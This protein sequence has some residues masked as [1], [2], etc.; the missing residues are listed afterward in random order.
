[1][2]LA[3]AVAAIKGSRN[4]TPHG[5]ARKV[6]SSRGPAAEPTKA[7][8][9]RVAKNS[10]F[11]FVKPHANTEATRALVSAGLTAAGLTILHEGSLGAELIDSKR[12]I[13]QHYYAIASKA[14]IL[15]PAQLNV[16]AALFEKTFGVPWADALQSGNVLNAMD[17]CARLGID[18]A[19]MEA[20]WRAAEAAKKLVKFGG[21]FY[22][23]LV[24]VDGHAPVYVFNGFFMAMRNKFTAPGVSIHYY[25]VEWDASQTS[26]KSFRGQLLGPTDPAAAPA[27]SLRGRINAQWQALGLHAAPNVGDN[28][29][30]ASASPFEALAER[31][32]WV[33]AALETDAFGASLLAAGIPAATI[34]EWTLDPQV[35]VGDGS[36]N[37]S[38]FDALEDTNAAE[39]L[40]ECKRLWLLNA[41]VPA[42]ASAP[43]AAVAA[44]TKSVAISLP[45][46][47]PVSAVEGLGDDIPLAEPI[48]ETKRLVHRGRVLQRSNPVAAF[49]AFQR[50]AALL[51]QGGSADP[52]GEL[53][54]C[55]QFSQGTVK[56]PA[57]AFELATRGHA[58]GSV[59]ATSSLA[60][61][62]RTGTGCERDPAKAFA[63]FSLAA[64]GQEP[65]GLCGLGVCYDDGIG[66]DKDATKAAACYEKAA[67][68]GHAQSISIIGL[69]YA[70]GSG[71]A[72]DASR[73]VEFYQRGA[74]LGHANSICNLGVCF[75]NG[76]GVDK[77]VV[78]A[79]ACYQRGAELGHAHSMYYLGLCYEFGKGA[80]DKSKDAAKAW[81]KKAAELG[82]LDAKKRLK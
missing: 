35:K 32:N 16:P 18:S 36:K 76:T 50:A 64:E 25:V 67:E 40:A 6:A 45:P 82:D 44:P 4:S 47:P 7:A 63:L 1:M 59:L 15:K 80:L 71:V 72:K 51:E 62:Y 9:A 54:H 23:G 22:C 55:Y 61:C 68:L 33:G 38:L 5:T 43:V 2:Q 70:N 79:V 48:A 73:A 24:Q 29:V 57:L 49:D 10:A 20:A 81:F 11:V 19:Q 37:G 42:P 75:E 41:P 58:A 69:C 74:V 27:G 14:T 77:D 52:L 78:Q 28:G 60:R 39:C 56:N 8:S 12:L 3:Q 17:A 21:G 26:W 65:W 13:D 30:H 53:S 46:L 31:M 66:C 34:R